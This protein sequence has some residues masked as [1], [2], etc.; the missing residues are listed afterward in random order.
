[1]LRAVGV[2][3]ILWYLSIQ[4]TQSLHAL[5]NASTAVFKMIETAAKTTGTHFE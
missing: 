5:D 4:F 3:L 1:M 2:I